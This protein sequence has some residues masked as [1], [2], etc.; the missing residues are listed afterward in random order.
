MFPR[1]RL[2]A[3]LQLPQYSPDRLSCPSG[4]LLG[5][6]VRTVRGVL[7]SEALGAAEATAHGAVRPAPSSLTPAG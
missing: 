3:V 1:R 4:H 5:Q 6:R 2:A 7:I